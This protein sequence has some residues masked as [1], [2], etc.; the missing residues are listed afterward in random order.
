MGMTIGNGRRTLVVAFL[1]GFQAA[2][3][4]VT[5]IR[6]LLSQLRGNELVIGVVFGAWFLGIYIGAAVSSRAGKTYWMRVVAASCIALPLAA[7]LSLYGSHLAATA[8]R[9]APGAFIAHSTE[10][11]VAFL[12]TFPVSLP[13]GLFFPPL[14]S[15]FSLT[16]GR[17]AGGTVFCVESLG[18]FAGGIV[19]SFLIIDHFNPLTVLLALCGISIAA[20]SNRG[21]AMAV[22]LVFVCASPFGEGAEQWFMQ[23]T[24]PL[25]HTGRLVHYERSRFQHIAVERMD[26]Q[27]SIYCNGIVLYSLPDQYETRSFFH[28]VEALRGDRRR[29]LLFGSP[30]AGALAKNFRA[31]GAKVDIV[32]PDIAL[33]KV[34][35]SLS[36][37]QQAG[38]SP[39]DARI[40][41]IARD[42][43]YYISHTGRRYDMII[44]LAHPPE[45]LQMNRFFT[46]EYFRR[47]RDRLAPGGI[48]IV[49]VQGFSNFMGDRRR[50]YIISIYKSFMSVFPD[51]VPTSGEAMYLLAGRD[52]PP[53]AG[54]PD[55]FIKAYSGAWSPG[56]DPEYRENFS[57][58]E[59]RAFFEKSQ[60]KYF[61]S[62][63]AP[64]MDRID[65][66]S[67]VRPRGFWKYLAYS[68]FRED[69][70]LVRTPVPGILLIAA[71]AA[72][73][74]ALFARLGSRY[75]RF[76]FH[77]GIIMA[78]TGYTGI[79]CMIALIVLYQQYQ[80]V[81][82]YRIALVNAVFML[83]LAAG[84][85][86]FR[87]PSKKTLIAV[88]GL[89]LLCQPLIA[90][91]AATGAEPVFWAGLALVS[92]VN[93]GVFPLLFATSPSSE[94]TATAGVL[95]ASDH[96]GALAGS[97]AAS[98]AVIPFAGIYGIIAMNFLC[99]VI[100]VLSSIKRSTLPGAF[101]GGRP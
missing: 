14:V 100:M 53:F 19:F 47:C 9:G 95:D 60:M 24:W 25:S 88:I 91:Y 98:L 90:A 74:G 31:S 87:R 2:I 38:Q 84:S 70:A 69:S 18:S 44:S 89:I 7:A 80:G 26:G 79:S 64:V 32:E 99:A 41:H 30:P 56:I 4:Q 97:L 22:A 77:N 67:D 23:K 57:P 49:A 1:M 92:F 51:C 83:G 55:S 12:V 93:G 36:P 75:G 81:V 21:P 20:V 61:S 73:C 40:G 94:T 54:G 13:V 48:M 72:A 68:L 34:A 86:A 96:F 101:E 29:I 50:D 58:D 35:M 52:G 71:A 45:N 16:G 28:L 78:C 46:A 6:E 82:Y 65:A 43:V 62:T 39:G 11:L 27:V 17:D 76:Q 37:T 5:L 3:V 63:I 42:M 66:N 33:W 59:L 8:F 10:M 85:L 15:I